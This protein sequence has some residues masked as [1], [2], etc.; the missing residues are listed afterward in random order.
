MRKK[1]NLGGFIGLIL[2]MGMCA[3]CSL[4]IN[5]WWGALGTTAQQIL[6]TV[7]GL[8]FGLFIFFIFGLAL[9]GTIAWLWYKKNS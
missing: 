2:L 7:G 4:G 3:V 6:L 1:S 5:P 9:F 8:G